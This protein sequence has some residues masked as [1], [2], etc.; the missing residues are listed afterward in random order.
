LKGYLSHKFRSFPF[1]VVT[2]S[3]H[4]DSLNSLENVV[5][6][7]KP[8]TNLQSSPEVVKIGISGF[9]KSEQFL[10]QMALQSI[11]VQPIRHG[12]GYVYLYLVDMDTKIQHFRKSTIRGYISIFF[13]KNIKIPQLHNATRG[14][15]FN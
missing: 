12:Y 1:P 8:V 9:D 13:K 2:R 10:V 7:V 4:A 15:G 11:D 14:S 3:T 5:V 6:T